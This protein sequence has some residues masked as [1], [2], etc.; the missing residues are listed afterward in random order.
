MHSELIALK[1]FADSLNISEEEKLQFVPLLR[2]V[3]KLVIKA[4]FKLART[5]KDKEIVENVLNQ[6][7]QHL[8]AQRSYIEETNQQLSRQKKII[9]E[10][11]KHKEQFFTKVSHELRTPLNG[12]LG[13][14]YLL[15]DTNL[16]A[17]QQEFVDV[18]RLSANNLLVIINDILEV[19]KI[20]LGKSK[21]SYK[22]F[23]IQNTLNLLYKLLEYKA[24]SK[25]VEFIFNTP[26]K[27]PEFVLGDSVRV[28]QILVNLLDNAIKFTTQ[29]SI[30]LNTSLYAASDQ[31]I[32]VQF[33]VVDTGIGIPSD[34]LEEIFETFTQ[35]QVQS[36]SYVEGT[37]LGLNIVK[38]FT[39]L[40]NGTVT[41]ESEVNQ[42]TTF[43]IVIPFKMPEN[44]T[45]Q[46]ATPKIVNSKQ[47]KTNWLTKKVL[48]IEDNEANLLYARHLFKSWTLSFDEAIT[49]AQATQ[50]AYKDRYDCLLVD[51][52]LPDGDGIELIKT[53]RADH[54]C[55]NQ[56]TPI[57]I[58]TAGGSKEEKQRADG[59]AIHAYL[60]KPF[61]PN[62]LAHCLEDIF[63][64]K[65]LVGLTKQKGKLQK[66][67]PTHKADYLAHLSKMV[68][69]NRQ[70][71]AE[72]IE[73][74]LEQIPI[75]ITNIEIGITAKDWEKVYF[76]AHKIKSTINIIGLME[77]KQI[78]EKINRYA[79]LKENV[80]QISGL[81]EAFKLIA[82]QEIAQLKIELAMLTKST[83]TMI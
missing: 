33:E 31:N 39:E 76:E 10:K 24:K 37:G 15:S 74:F 46:E 5:L 30:H 64:E 81:F 9:E 1:K 63:V 12:V 48:L 45:V 18:I 8:Q 62:N 56:K 2:R 75:T 20:N 36:D 26:N 68:Y 41:V 27:L 21:L 82:Q 83:A 25:G 11:S 53:I 69:G 70:Y 49:H 66:A 80:A 38:Q 44:V 67:E 57:I 4:D 60:L 58:L 17:K 59:L 6:S 29:G 79:Y 72:M 43:K 14:S 77:L 40:M 55:I 7:I 3:E 61:E 65:Q 54:T 52:G 42:G 34:M 32:T 16:D 50:Q 13:M 78:V 73:I 47:T 71:M 51:V 28:Y 19:S 23:S 22:P 35:V